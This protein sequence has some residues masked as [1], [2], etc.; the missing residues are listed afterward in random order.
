MFG[1]N[2][3]DEVRNVGSPIGVVS[4][5]LSQSRTFYIRIGSQAWLILESLSSRLVVQIYI[6]E[7][8]LFGG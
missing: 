3:F 2:F 7:V 5:V 8:S 6:F 4:L 1:R